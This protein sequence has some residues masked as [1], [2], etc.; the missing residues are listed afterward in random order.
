MRLA[1]SP[2]QRNP[3]RQSG[4]Q[5]D[6][7]GAVGIAA[8]VNFPCLKDRQVSKRGPRHRQPKEFQQFNSFFDVHARP[9]R[10][11][12]GAADPAANLARG[13]TGAPD[14]H[15][16]PRGL[17]MALESHSRRSRPQAVGLNTD[18]NGTPSITGCACGPVPAHA[19]NS[20][21]AV[22]L[23]GVR[24]FAALTPQSSRPRIPTS[25]RA[26]KGARRHFTKAG[27]FC[28]QMGRAA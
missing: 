20:P 5:Q 11:T 19:A 9:L 18:S 27:S 28:R 6:G 17:C 4:Y 15:R 21:Y 25:Q 7:G 3:R 2:F 23:P 26:V 22:S 16:G 13:R 10:V 24:H 14:T 12:V 1:A 8:R